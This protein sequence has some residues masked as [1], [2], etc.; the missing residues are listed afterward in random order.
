VGRAEVHPG[1]V[2][3]RL[4]DAGRGAHEATVEIVDAAAMEVAGRPAGLGVEAVARALDPTRSVSA[5]TIAGGTAPAEVRRM[6]ARMAA[7]LAKD[8][9]R[10]G[11]WRERLAVSGAERKTALRALAEG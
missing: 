9:A 1:A 5:R 8:E 11:V 4:M 2:V 10:V 6:A 3:R 7:R